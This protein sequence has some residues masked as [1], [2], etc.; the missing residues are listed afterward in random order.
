MTQSKITKINK[1]LK[2]YPIIA[3]KLQELA[4]FRNELVHNYLYL[5]HK[6]TFNIFKNNFETFK[7]YS[8]KIEK[9][10]KDS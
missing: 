6:R 7:N 5:D 9:F 3:E 1:I 2:K 8:K 4:G 10:L